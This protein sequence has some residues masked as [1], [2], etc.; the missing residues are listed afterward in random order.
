MRVND[1]IESSYPKEDIKILNE[2]CSQFLNEAGNCP[3]L[4]FL[5]NKYNDFH[6]VKVRRRKNYNAGKEEF[7]GAF[8]EAF[9]TQIKDL[10][11]RAV[12]AN[13]PTSL[14]KRE[15]TDQDPFYIF[16]IDGFKFM[17]S[18]EVEHSSTDYKH[19]FDAMFEAFG[20][21]KGNEI[22]TELL[23]FNYKSSNIHEGI[24]QG[25]EIILYNIPY[26]YAVRQ[27]T[28]NYNQLVE[29]LKEL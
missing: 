9:D 22:I 10:R 17:Y 14:Q 29:Q 3:L 1:L 4:K 27:T 23:K 5:P 7:A 20:H 24:V 16:P 6:K 8:N 2:R 11:E 25:A 13:G 28:I 15:K 18:T 26:F 19:V 21:D 12:F